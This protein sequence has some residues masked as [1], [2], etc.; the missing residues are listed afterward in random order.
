M[1]RAVQRVHFCACLNNSCSCLLECMVC[2]VCLSK[3]FLQLLARVHGLFSMLVQYASH[4]RRASCRRARPASYFPLQLPVPMCMPHAA[5]CFKYEMACINAGQVAGGQD[6]HPTS[7]CSSLCPCVCLMQ[8]YASKKKWLVQMQGKLQE[9]KT[10]MRVAGLTRKGMSQ[11]MP[12]SYLRFAL[13]YCLR[14]YTHTYVFYY[15]TF[16]IIS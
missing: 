13:C 16:A 1:L 3:Q 7:H 10:I 11:N 5:V 15:H 6:Q 14:T 8:Q 9:G 4:K 2:S 12:A